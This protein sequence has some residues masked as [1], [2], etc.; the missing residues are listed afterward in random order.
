[1]HF[2]AASELILNPDNSVYHL[3]LTPN[4]V[5]KTIFLVGDPNRVEQVSKRFDAVTHKV[6]YREFVTHTGRLG[7]N[8]VTVLSTGIGTDNIDIVLNEL[9]AL[10]NIDFNTR[11]P[12]AEHTQL[13]II[14][15]GTSGS[16][17]PTLQ[18]GTFLASH[19]AVGFDNL[20]HFYKRNITNQAASLTL[21]VNNVLGDM[22][23]PFYTAEADQELILK[24]GS[25]F[26]KGITL[27]CAGFYAPQNRNLRLTP[28]FN[29]WFNAMATLEW[30]G[31][32]CTNLEMETAGIYG[33]SGLLGHKALSLN[34]ILA[35]RATGTFHQNPEMAVSQLIDKALG[36]L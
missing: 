32:K 20:L 31:L 23:L 25:Q 7:N 33:L 26:E 17:Q 22:K 24:A 21:A 10:F 14:R 13:N 35:N 16:L 28:R 4:Q 30:Q 11:T 29:D 8:E 19:W 12:K 34:A 15:I 9:D 1:M 3:H 36:L 18:V 5:A 6:S 2:F 27:T